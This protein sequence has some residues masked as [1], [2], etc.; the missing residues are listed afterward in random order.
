MH[1]LR[2]HRYNQD[3]YEFK[4]SP[5]WRDGMKVL[6]FHQHFST[7]A[8]TAGTRSYEF[9]RHLI[10]RGHHVTMVCGSYAGGVTGLSSHFRRGRR[11][12]EVEGIHVV[13][14]E[15]PYS[16][17][18]SF[19]R[20]ALTFAKFALRSIQVA[21]VE[22]YDVVFATSTPLTAGLPGIAASILRWKPFVF[23]VRDLWP[24]L[25][26]AM[27]VIKNPFMLRLMSVLEW[28]SY[29]SASLCIGL[30]PGIVDGIRR[31]GIS[32]DRVRFI[33]NGCDL[34]VFGEGVSE[35]W[36]PDGVA[37]D[38]LMA[39]FAGTHGIA[40]GL[41]AVLDAAGELS[42]RGRTDIKLVLVGS[43]ALKQRLVERAARDHLTNC[44]FLPPIPKQKLAG[45]LASADV[46][47]MVLA[48]IPAFYFGT[49]PNK[50]F[51]YISAGLPVLNNYPGWVAE[52]IAENRCGIAVPPD[53]A[54]AFADALQSMAERRDE[55]IEMG[56]NGR[57]LAE[58]DFDRMALADQFVDAL[59]QV[60]Q[61]A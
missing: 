60:V 47:L 14:F 19:L 55:L 16:N 12:G 24:E 33:P 31:R 40:N 51:D 22:G 45:L 59:Q 36:R 7:R 10:A 3:N 29:H 56:Q 8:G 52:L 50:F 23:E 15:L 11:S 46:G 42:R 6:Y 49:S 5:R 58:R 61:R 26:R 17:N 28:M 25:P 57:A 9:A 4:E 21:L 1:G 2:R 32:A 18:D 54:V 13:E 27:G 38:D 35:P 43:G 34:E 20:R 39:V 30:A 37:P 48:N 53:D 41:E 44:V